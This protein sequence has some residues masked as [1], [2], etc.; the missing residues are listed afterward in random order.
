MNYRFTDTEIKKLLKENFVILVDTREQSNQHV[1]D[2][3]D[4]KKINYKSQVINE[5][6]Y[7]AIITKRPEMG[8]YR[9]LYFP[10]AVERKNSIDEIAGN[11]AD[12][13]DS[14]DDV[15]LERE[16][17]RAKSKGIKIFLLVEDPKGWK[18]IQNGSYRS[19]YKSSSLIG[20]LTKTEVR[21]LNGTTFTGREDSAFHIW[22]LL[23][24]S[25]RDYLQSGELDMLN[26][27]DD[28]VCNE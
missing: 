11:F 24:Y 7:T 27:A 4:D 18:T 9:D 20:R 13:V 8:I 12:K 6:D 22:R 5:G 1:L 26:E 2:G 19:L 14:R 23:Y 15:R 3:F 10:V 16:L 21:Y 17:I 25:I 28:E